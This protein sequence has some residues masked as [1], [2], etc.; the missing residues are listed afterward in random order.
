MNHMRYDDSP[1]PED[2]PFKTEARKILVW[3]TRPPTHDVKHRGSLANICLDGMQAFDHRTMAVVAT[4]MGTVLPVKEGGLRPTDLLITPSAG[5][6]GGFE[7]W[8]VRDT[9]H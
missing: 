7:V 9:L 4:K 2:K 5:E 3:Q 1:P 6:D 8:R